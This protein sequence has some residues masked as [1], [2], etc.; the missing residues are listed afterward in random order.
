MSVRGL[1]TARSNVSTMSES[2][3]R[4]LEALR[5]KAL[6][7]RSSK[8]EKLKTV[9][10]KKLVAKYGNK[11]ADVI[12]EEVD[13]FITATMDKK[14]VEKD[15][16][17]LENK[18]REKCRVVDSQRGSARPTNRTSRIGTVRSQA[19]ARPTARSSARVTARSAAPGASSPGPS[20]LRSPREAQSRAAGACAAP[21]PTAAAAAAWA[22]PPRTSR[23]P[24]SRP[25]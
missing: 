5:N 15:L 23:P 21:V 6:G 8:R 10:K 24:G 18:I 4:K 19:S 13:R 20:P 22:P 9:L 11:W 12:T 1:D 25:G 14:L 16:A 2:R 17:Q 7:P 3:R